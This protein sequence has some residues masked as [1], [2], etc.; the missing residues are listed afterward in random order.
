MFRDSGSPSGR[1]LPPINPP[2][3][4]LEERVSSC[5]R[6]LRFLMEESVRSRGMVRLQ[7][8]QM[9]HGSGASLQEAAQLRSQL[10]STQAQMASF[11]RQSTRQAFLEVERERLLTAHE[12]LSNQVLSHGISIAI[13]LMMFPGAVGHKYWPCRWRYERPLATRE[14]DFPA[15]RTA[16]GGDQ[17]GDGGRGR[18]SEE[19]LRHPLLS[20]G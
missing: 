16:A 6:G 12:D 10:V 13:E 4:S 17:Q 20:L 19:A 18:L 8:Q 9:G 3:V 5:E 15:G 11:M 1:T 2:S 14:S 7:L